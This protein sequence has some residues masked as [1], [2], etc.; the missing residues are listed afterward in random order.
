MEH[1][2]DFMEHDGDFMR[3]VGNFKEHNGNFYEDERDFMEH[4]DDFMEYARGFMEYSRSFVQHER[5]FLGLLNRTA[6]TNASGDVLTQGLTHTWLALFVF[7]S[8]L[9][10]SSP[11][12][13]VEVYHI[14]QTWTILPTRICF[15]DALRS[16]NPPPPSYSKA[17]YTIS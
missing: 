12:N 14:K 8:L 9:E 7:Y 16:N 15:I 6:Y 5:N 4:Y 2:G 17:K 3:H 13:L 1:D 10:R 11:I